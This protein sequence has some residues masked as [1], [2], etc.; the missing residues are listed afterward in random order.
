MKKRLVLVLI[1][2]LI[3]SILVNAQGDPN[4]CTIDLVEE[5][6]GQGCIDNEAIEPLE[7]IIDGQVLLKL[8]FNPSE[9]C[10]THALVDITFGSDPEGWLVNIGDSITN[11]GGGGDN[12][13]QSNNA[14]LEIQDSDLRI[15]GSSQMILDEAGED[16]DNPLLLREFMGIIEEE[17]V[18]TLVI[19]NESI[20][21]VHDREQET[22]T[23]PYLFALDGQDDESGRV[24]YS[25][26]LA[27]NRLIRITEDEEVES[28]GFGVE[29][30]N[31]SLLGECD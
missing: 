6:Y 3:P 15:F 12:R 25:I 31:I 14:E 11:N 27:F 21:I 24:N 18:L 23:S 26:F 4:L 9:F 1:L 17:S 7:D 5:E 22:I 8:S 19:S 20:S 28:T 30:V 29:Q 16:E 2:C 10:H 13:T